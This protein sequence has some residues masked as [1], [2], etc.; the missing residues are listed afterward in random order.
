MGEMNGGTMMRREGWER[1]LSAEIRD[2]DGR[3]FEWGSADC[4]GFCRAVAR[5]M[6]GADPIPDLPAYGSEY[7]AAKVLVGLGHRSLE[8]LVDAHLPR[9]PVARARRGDWVMTAAEG[10]M[11]GAMGVVTG[12]HALHL[13]AAG[14]V[15][16][17]VL[18]AEAAWCVD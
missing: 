11:P 4:L 1:R 2:W 3:A 13:G 8:D 14:L 12:R 15:R 17:P 6:T 5:A 7:T 18:T 16:R 10:A 9:V